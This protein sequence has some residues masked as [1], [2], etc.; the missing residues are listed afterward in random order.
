MMLFE[1]LCTSVLLYGLHVRLLT[2]GSLKRLERWQNRSL[3]RILRMP[4]FEENNSRNIMIRFKAKTHSI[5]TKLRRRRL[6]FFQRVL[7]GGR[8]TAAARAVLFGSF[9]WGDGGRTAP[10]LQ[11]LRSDV[12]ILIAK[13]SKRL[14]RSLGELSDQQQL[15]VLSQATAMM[16]SRVLSVYSS[17]D[18]TRAPGADDEEALLPCPEC[19]PKFKPNRA[20]TCNRTG[21][22]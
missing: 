9:A 4:S 10:R 18:T 14:G 16:Q 1:A 20:R 3:R 11:L 19:G 7:N 5:E 12:S 17:A 6:R 13:N 22:D 2:S 8:D 21:A 15:G